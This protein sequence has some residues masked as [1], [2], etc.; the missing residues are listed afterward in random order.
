MNKP[1]WMSNPNIRPY[2]FVREENRIANAGSV[3]QFPWFEHNY[4]M[5]EPQKI[6]NS[7]FGK[8]ILKLDELAFGHA[9]MPTPPWVFYDCGVMP[10]LV[11]GYAAKTKF[12][13]PI[14]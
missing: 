8:S 3:H 9:G 1:E 4:M 7:D 14:F 2:V 6:E 5:F 11:V 10:G 13:P 12:L